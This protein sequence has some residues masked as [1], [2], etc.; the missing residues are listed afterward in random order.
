MRAR[1][2]I[3]WSNKE[4][5]RRKRAL[6]GFA[7][8]P[9]LATSLLL[10]ALLAAEVLRRLLMAD[11]ADVPAAAVSASQLWVAAAVC[12]YAIVVFGAPFRLYWRRDS[13]L[14]ASL[15]VPGS[16]LFALALWRSH[17]S[18]LQVSVFL[19][20]ALVP[21]GLLVDWSLAL[22]HVSAIAIGFV[23]AAWLGPAAALAAGAIVA[24]DKA[25][26]MINS[27]GGEFQAPRTSWLGIFPGLAATAVAIGIIACAPWIL[28]SRPP[29]GSML[30]IVLVAVGTSA[31]SLAWAWARAAQVIPAAVREVAALDQEILAH[32]ERSQPSA[33]EARFISATLSRPAGLV[34]RKDAALLR[35]RYP[36]PYF[37]IPGGIVAIW[38]VAASQ[39]AS[40]LPWAGAFFGAI[41][42]YSV[43]MA[44]RAQSEPVEIPRL[45]ATLPLAPGDVTSAKNALSGLRIGLIVVTA[46]PLLVAR[47]PDRLSAGIFVALAAGL[48]L[49]ASLRR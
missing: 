1:S 8:L 3:R 30:L 32:V 5:R 16:S 36:S 41:L 44:R 11:E 2:L 18:A 35:R 25:Q 28:G 12:G 13:K 40:Y 34:A 19:L 33:L 31:A 45:L 24:S 46:A 4:E 26:A 22:R 27:M 39:P 29:G 14:L 7:A 15:P 6:G 42:A 43:V 9:E 47:A 38:I 23:G 10:G 20:V 48:A 49:L 17:R 21:S 37:M